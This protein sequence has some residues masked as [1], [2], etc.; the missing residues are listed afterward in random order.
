MSV[1]EQS[2]LAELSSVVCVLSSICT[3]LTDSRTFCVC[4]YCF[5]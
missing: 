5:L 1:R 4:R 2:S 3:G